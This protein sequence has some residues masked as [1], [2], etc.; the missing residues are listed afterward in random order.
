MKIRAIFIFCMIFAVFTAL[1][2]RVYIISTDEGYKEQAIGQQSESE[3]LSSERGNIYDRNGTPL[4]ANEESLYIVIN[5]AERIYVSEILAACEITAQQLYDKLKTEQVFSLKVENEEMISNNYLRY[6]QSSRSDLSYIASNILGYTDID[7]VGVSG[8]EKSFN[9]LLSEGGES[10]V[11]N[12]QTNGFNHV[13]SDAS[14]DLIAVDGKN[15]GV[16]LTLDRQIQEIVEEMGS[17]VIERG[18]IVISKVSSGEI[19]ASATFPAQNPAD[20]ESDMQNENLPL[21]NRAFMSYNVGSVFKIVVA[22]AALETNTPINS[23]FICD[24]DM[25]I[26]GVVFR[27]HERDGHG[28]LDLMG[29]I[30]VSCNPYFIELGNNVGYNEIYA[31][32]NIMGFNTDTNFATGINSVTGY[33]PTPNPENSDILYSNIY[34]GQG[35][36]LATPVQLNSLMATVAN[37]GIY[38]PPTLILETTENGATTE[39]EKVAPKRVISAGT[40]ALLTDALVGVV[41]EGS[42]TK[43]YTSQFSVAGKTGS[44]QTGQ[45][46]GETEKV[47]AWF[48]G[49]YPANNPK[50]AITILIEEGIYGSEVAA[51]LFTQIASEIERLVL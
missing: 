45:Y 34:F 46:S 3:V 33:L 5:P 23:E 38:N 1:Y 26:G 37:D 40:A 35:E 14:L 2:L 16:T 17:D 36:L 50:Y 41:E 4:I 25:E 12:Y 39:M 20:I 28:E 19:V 22:A 10:Y 7:N 48:S 27:C 49:F 51:P 43:A 29:A 30:E 8:I 13:G 18:A 32:A 31:L 42:A 15:S 21:I 24:G 11:V 9:D 44:A 6:I 47:H